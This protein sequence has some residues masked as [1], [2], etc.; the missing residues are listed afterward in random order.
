MTQTLLWI[1]I[2][3]TEPH[4]MVNTI[5]RTNCHL[6]K[7]SGSALF[8]VHIILFIVSFGLYIFESASLEPDLFSSPYPRYCKRF[9]KRCI[10]MTNTFQEKYERKPLTFYPEYR[11]NSWHEK[12]KADGKTNDIIKITWKLIRKR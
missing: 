12:I 6:E 10:F 7:K 11:V 8:K 4:R 9:L 2:K 5:A 3:Y 1:N